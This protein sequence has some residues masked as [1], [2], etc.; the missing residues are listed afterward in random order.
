MGE[1]FEV[2]PEDALPEVEHRDQ[3]D[4]S[5]EYYENGLRLVSEGEVLDGLVSLHL[6]KEHL[7]GKF[8]PYGLDKRRSLEETLSAID[9]AITEAKLLLREHGPKVHWVNEPAS[10]ADISG[11]D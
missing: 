6:S 11:R 2:H 7:V 5:K 10:E 4:M 8:A 1:T 3:L 9:P